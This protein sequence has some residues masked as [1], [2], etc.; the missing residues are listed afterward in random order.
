MELKSD[1]KS[2]TD[3]L[4]DFYVLSGMR[5]TVFDDNFIEIAQ[6][7]KELC[8]FCA[9]LRSDS[10]MRDKCM[11]SDARAFNI[12]KKS[13]GLHIYKCHAG[14]YEAAAPLKYNGI[15][16]G[17][18]M[19][20]QIADKDSRE[21]GWSKVLDYLKELP[22]DFTKLRTAYNQLGCVTET[23]LH[24]AAKILEACA[25]YIHLYNCF[26]PAKEDIYQ[27]LENYIENNIDSKLTSDVICRELGISRATLYIASS[28]HFGMGVAAYIKH[29]RLQLACRLLQMTNYKIATVASMVGIQDYNYFT[30]LFKKETGMTPK[31][32]RKKA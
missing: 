26:A 31:E 12:C 2:L 17:Y 22:V 25:C 18:I 1:T 15:I 23:Q 11:Q 9:L 4:R 14:L 16:I 28:K 8:S 5:T 32:F 29:K 6:Y 24:A 30:K 21:Q 3:L 19:L 7:P 10:A 13:G 27:R 20:G